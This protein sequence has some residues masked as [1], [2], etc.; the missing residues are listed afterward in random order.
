M[1]TK[2]Q[3]KFWQTKFYYND[4]RWLA[5]LMS[6]ILIFITLSHHQPF[7]V[8]GIL[9]LRTADAFTQHGLKAAIAVYNWP[10]YSIL[11][12]I[13]S[14]FLNLSLLSAAYL[15]N[16]VLVIITTI[17]FI[18]IIKT[19]GGT[20]RTQILAACIILIFPYYN[21][22]LN[23]IMRGFGYIAFF[24]VALLFLI[25]YSSKPSWRNA[26]GWGI[27]MLIAMLF[28]IE[29]AMFFCAGPIALFLNRQ[30]SFKNRFIYF[31]KAHAVLISI[32]SIVLMW[33]FVKNNSITM[34]GD[35]HSTGRLAFLF[36]QFQH[37]FT[38]I[39]HEFNIRE[40]IYRT[41]ILNR[42]SDE[43]APHMLFGGLIT[44]FI[45]TLF[46]TL[47][48]IY[49]ILSA[50]GIC[51]RLITGKK[52]QNTTALKIIITFILLNILVLSVFLGQ[53]YFLS[54][55]YLLA[56]CLLLMLWVPFG[57]EKIWDNWK[58]KKLIMTGKRW[59]FPL[60]C[61]LLIS[62]A[63]DDLLRIGPSKTYVVDAGQ[64]IEKNTDQK[65]TLF[66]NS[67]QLIFYAQRD[68][69]EI[70]SRIDLVKRLNTE[71]IQQYDYFAILIKRKKPE[72]ADTVKKIFQREPIKEFKNRRGDR[73]FIFSRLENP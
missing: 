8:D 27:A 55:R 5:A 73:V 31:I 25:R 35:T 46:K 72:L 15:I 41:M 23:D 69:N 58:Q 34:L 12:S 40:N 37:G 44:L 19:L 45:I 51:Q 26:L 60:I 21:H 62:M 32:I 48:P 52:P 70:K 2:T 71:T 64:W 7:N 47:S 38:Q 57:L 61:L 24:L 14:R 56:L 43:L 29:G 33:M 10:F 50:Y 63:A 16:T 42:Y 30:W 53:R 66:A 22:M 9:Y 11:I 28:R 1:M 68:A 13:T 4:I 65:A 18:T 36:S 59:V 17:T 49:L 39:I 20:R 54:G 3:Q 67:T 6:I